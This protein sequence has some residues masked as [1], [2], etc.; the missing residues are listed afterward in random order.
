VFPAR[1]F[2]TLLRIGN[3]CNGKMPVTHGVVDRLDSATRGLRD[4]RI[5]YRPGRLSFLSG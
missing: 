3:S 5:E 2:G 1:S 4:E